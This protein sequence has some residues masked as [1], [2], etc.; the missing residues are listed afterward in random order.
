MDDLISDFVCEA[1]AALAGL[2]AGLVRISAGRLDA[3]TAADMLRRL[4]G[5]R[6]VCG[7]VGFTRAEAL[8]Q[9][10]EAV[11]SAA[12]RGP[13]SPATV[14]VLGEL[15]ERL[16]IIFAAGGDLRSE[17][18]G[19]DQALVAALE[20][21]ALDVGRPGVEAAR[22]PALP[23]ALS[24]SP[25]DRR[26]R[27]PWAGLDV[28]AR[29]LG[30]RL[31][32]RID[33]TVGGDNL[34]IAPEA[35]GPLRTALIALVRNA[36]DHGI[37]SPA[38]RRAAG[39]PPLAVIELSVQHAAEGAGIELRDDGR[40][41]DPERIRACCVAAG[42]LDRAAAAALDEAQSQALIFLPGVTTAGAVTA[43][44]GRG[45]GLELVRHELESLGGAVDL[46][47]TPGKGACFMLSLPATAIASPAARRVAA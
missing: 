44:S 19:D 46:A 6:G 2:Q 8:A 3:D 26:A 39:K 4:H 11:L 18:D 15:V 1:A 7:F 17:P 41:V 12:S 43:L 37:E 24:S 21:A 13:A 35:V 33:L 22:P 27:A 20:S 45:L 42:R 28:L 10:G 47:S 32:K 34:R 16:G 14:A 5:L 25:P 9:A 23:S 29:S 40:G 36:C 38:E 30:D 31:G